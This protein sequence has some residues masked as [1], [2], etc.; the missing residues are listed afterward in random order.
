LLVQ[1]SA[2]LQSV[3]PDDQSLR[4]GKTWRTSGPRDAPDGSHIELAIEVRKQ[5]AAARWF[6]LQSVTAGSSLDAR[7]LFIHREI[8]R[9]TPSYNKQA[10]AGKLRLSNLI[11]GYPLC[12]Y[13]ALL[14]RRAEWLAWR[15]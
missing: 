7:E 4:A 15:L 8:S 6:P 2:K 11:P 14:I 13:C 1:R 5:R 10:I 3:R 12:F 9:A